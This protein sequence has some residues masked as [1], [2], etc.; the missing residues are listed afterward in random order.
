M[1]RAIGLLLATVTVLCPPGAGSAEG[2]GSAPVP[3]ATLG[4]LFAALDRAAASGDAEEAWAR[5][6]AAGTMPLVFGRTAVFLYR[7]PGETVEW[8]GDLD[9]WEEGPTT[10]GERV[11]ATDLWWKV[12]QL[13][14]GSRL[15]YKI[16]VDGGT[17]LLDP[18][19]PHAQLGGYGP[20]S[21]ARVPPW[22]P[23]E[24]VRRRPDG[25]HG[26]LGERTPVP[27][28]A[29]GYDV[30][31]RVYEPAGYDP[32]AAAPYPLLVVTDGSDYW[33]EE[34]GSLVAVLDNLIA[35]GALP[36]LVAVFVDPWDRPGGTNRR[37]PELIPSGPW[38]SPFLEFLADELLPHVAQA[39][40][41][42]ETGARTAILGTSFG[43]L[44]ATYAAATRPDRFGLA[45]VQS[46]AYWP[47]PWLLPAVANAERLPRRVAL[48][49]GSYERCA[50]Y[51]ARQMR[52]ALEGRGVELLY[53]EV[54]DG[55]SWGHWR[56]TV[57]EGL[58][59]LF[60]TAGAS[61]PAS[62]AP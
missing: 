39:W 16:V 1:P 41:V 20:N 51:Q 56:A 45:A 4:E 50:A 37:E 22:Q 32:G 54:P 18:A 59:Y 49:V 11:G 34:M 13:A 61:A 17:W 47:S 26:A 55:H 29:L 14:P 19:N 7:G 27:S 57:G 38:P 8:R 31:V 21:E 60:A 53:R 12:A 58:A 35:D 24:E 42:D 25:P 15:D 62:S 44:F 3:F 33:H 40:P 5:A 9:G 46:P 30:S 23:P 36:P 43:G 48:D 10:H 6:Q 28:R 2:A 52:A